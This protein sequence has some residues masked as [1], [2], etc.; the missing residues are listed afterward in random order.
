[1]QTNNP[2]PIWKLYFMGSKQDLFLPFF[3]PFLLSFLNLFSLKN[4]FLCA[5]QLVL[6]LRY[7]QKFLWNIFEYFK[8]LSLF[9]TRNSIEE[10]NFT[11]VLKVKYIHLISKDGKKL[12][13]F[14][15][16]KIYRWKKKFIEYS[17][18]SFDYIENDTKWG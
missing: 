12:K 14:I 11:Y 2:R 4:I 3:F 16:I 13:Y 1:M 18:F 9:N 15:C 10:E 7:K 17:S 5:F 6:I 8:I